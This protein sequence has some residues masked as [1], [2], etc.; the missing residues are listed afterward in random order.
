MRAIEELT[1]HQKMWPGLR[2]TAEITS[3]NMASLG[4]SS[5]GNR[6][7]LE[8]YIRVTSIMGVPMHWQLLTN[9]FRFSKRDCFLFVYFI[10]SLPVI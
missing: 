5:T 2:V 8:P 7:S 4:D 1:F 3:K 6:G 9:A 10:L